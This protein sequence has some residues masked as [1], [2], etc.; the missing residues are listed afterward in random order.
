MMGEAVEMVKLVS[1]MDTVLFVIIVAVTPAWSRTTLEQLLVIPPCSSID[2]IV[3]ND[4]HGGEV[5]EPLPRGRH[6]LSG[7]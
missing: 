5:R 1:R 3:V 7:V 6:P 4:L 2:V